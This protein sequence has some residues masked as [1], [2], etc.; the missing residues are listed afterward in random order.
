MRSAPSPQG[1]A[2]SVCR[3]A[4][5][6][7]L[8]L[9]DLQQRPALGRFSGTPSDHELLP[10]RP[11]ALPGQSVR[12]PLFHRE[13]RMRTNSAQ[14]MKDSPRASPRSP[15]PQSSGKKSTKKR[16]RIK[17]SRPSADFLR[18]SPTTSTTPSASSTAGRRCWKDSSGKKARTWTCWNTSTSSRN[19]L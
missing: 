19:Q 8:R 7:P 17:S 9:K 2:S 10:R 6:A 15:L 3:C 14:K 5:P 11:V 4:T 1:K 13:T 12:K 18:A 16:S